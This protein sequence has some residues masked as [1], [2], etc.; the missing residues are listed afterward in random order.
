MSCNKRLCVAFVWT[1]WLSLVGSPCV[2]LMTLLAGCQWC[3]PFD[4]T[5]HVPRRP[6]DAY[7]STCTFAANKIVTE[8]P[9]E[10]ESRTL[11]L[12]ECILTALERNPKTRIAWQASR[13]RAFQVGQERSGFWPQLD[14]TGAMA[15][16]DMLDE[17]KKLES[18]WNA[19]NALFGVR[20]L[21]LD[22]GLR[23]A[24]VRGAEAELMAANFQHNTVL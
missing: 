16:N 7:W 18:P 22:G 13:T 6:S 9:D 15:R 1:L 20:Y 5:A 21:I 4:E 17:R 14:L 19:T 8:T 24:R 12:A 10:F 23:N 3:D 11:N 2:I